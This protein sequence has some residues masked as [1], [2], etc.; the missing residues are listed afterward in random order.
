MYH[1]NVKLRASST[2]DTKNVKNVDKRLFSKSFVLHSSLLCYII[3]EAQPG[4]EGLIR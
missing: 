2:P 1:K 3:K 4:R